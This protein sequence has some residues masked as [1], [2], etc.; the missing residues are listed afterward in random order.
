MGIR[1]FPRDM[2]DDFSFGLYDLDYEVFGCH[3]DAH[4][5]RV[6]AVA[7]VGIASTVRPHSIIH[8]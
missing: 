7:E 1:Y 5:N 2:E 3:L 6:P 4:V 8:E